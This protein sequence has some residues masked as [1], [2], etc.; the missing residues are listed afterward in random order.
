MSL[1]S[2]YLK[3]PFGNKGVNESYL[4]TGYTNSLIEI[5]DSPNKKN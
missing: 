1:N 5:I 2:N 3:S 4:R